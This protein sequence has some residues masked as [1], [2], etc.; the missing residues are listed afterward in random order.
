MV[1]GG[2]IF[3]FDRFANRVF[4]EIVERLRPLTVF[5]FESVTVD[6]TSSSDEYRVAYS[7][8]RLNFDFSFSMRLRSRL[9][10]VLRVVLVTFKLQKVFHYKN[11][12]K[13]FLI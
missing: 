6:D 13:I 7:V 5:V 2:G 4:P 12:Q 11:R 9:I 1:G 3:K 8:S 10:K